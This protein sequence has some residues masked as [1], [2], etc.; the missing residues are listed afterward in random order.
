MKPLTL[1]SAL[2]CFI[3][4][5]LPGSY[6]Q[7]KTVKWAVQKHGTLWVNGSSN[8]NT[9][10]C[11]ITGISEYDTI[12]VIYDP[13]RAQTLRGSIRMNILSFDCQNNLI[14]KDLRKTLKADQYPMMTIRFLTLRTM[15]SL[16]S[17]PEVITGWVEVELAGVKKKFELS[18]S[19]LQTSPGIINL[20]GGRKFCFSDFKLAPPQKFAG[21]VKIK[22]DFDVN[23]R[24]VL[25]TL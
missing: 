2:L 3:L 6:A 22:D 15:P 1:I 11:S 17:K 4:M 21:L 13:V 14:R 7:N 24:L 18:Y 23:F 12:V 9:I 8:V 25:K 20:N 16:T 19:F 10:S 5:N